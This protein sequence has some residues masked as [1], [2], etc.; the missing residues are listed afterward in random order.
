MRVINN[1][2]VGNGI[3]GGGGAAAFVH[4]SNAGTNNTQMSA[5]VSNDLIFG[6]TKPVLI[7]NVT[8]GVV[9]GANNW[10]ATGVSPGSLTN[11]V[12]SALPGFRNAA[13]K[14]FTLATNS[15]AIGGSD[16]SAIGL[17]SGEYYRDETVAR[18]YRV[19]AT[20]KD[21]GAFESTTGGAGIG[22]YDAPPAPKLGA[23]TSGRNVVISWPVGAEGF[24][25]EQTGALGIS[26]SWTQAPGPYVTNATNVVVS[27]PVSASNGF[28]R[29]RKG[30]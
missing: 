11:S 3:P 10:L 16:E 29:L 5:E 9:T 26:N 25:L 27:A 2:Y 13:G 28:F 22:P 20:A 15:A 4:L 30:F 23:A 21:I 6:T 18:E 12:F 14:D 8:N 19:R 17:P 24:A 7:E 1:T